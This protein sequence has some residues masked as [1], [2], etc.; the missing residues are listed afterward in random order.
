[1]KVPEGMLKACEENGWHPANRETL[2]STLEAALRWLAEHPMVPGPHDFDHL[3][4]IPAGLQI[5][6]N[7]SIDWQR[8]MFLEPKLPDQIEVMFKDRTL[9]REQADLVIELVNRC[10]S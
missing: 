7:A 6:I 9:T 8:R 5:A 10:V 4:L 3:N 1:M 2:R